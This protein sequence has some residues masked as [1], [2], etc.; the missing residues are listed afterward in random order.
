MRKP[1][2]RRSQPFFNTKKTDKHSPAFLAF[3]GRNTFMALEKTELDFRSHWVPPPPD[4]WQHRKG[5]NFHAVQRANLSTTESRK[6]WARAR[7]GAFCIKQIVPPQ[8]LFSRQAL[9][10]LRPA[11]FHNCQQG[12]PRDH[13]PVELPLSDP[14]S[15]LCSI[16][17]NL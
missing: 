13:N 15:Y 17:R 4:E 2:V 9:S 5:I 6:G 3:W 7:K 16:C 8:L 12:H 10:T 14:P 1:P 11:I